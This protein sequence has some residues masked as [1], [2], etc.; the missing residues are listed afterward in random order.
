L[1]R[2]H[3]RRRNEEL[4]EV[5]SKYPNEM[6]FE[7]SIYNLDGSSRIITNN[8]NDDNDNNVKLQ[9]FESV[10]FSV[11]IYARGC[12]TSFRFLNKAKFLKFIII[13]NGITMPI[14]VPFDNNTSINNNNVDSCASSLVSV[15]E[16]SD[17]N[18][19]DSTTTTTLSAV[20]NV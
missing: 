9:L 10:I 20:K 13:I 14:V 16:E 2:H 8:N 18:I 19:V 3:R 6:R 15:E 1:L 11:Y 17:N 7:K 12:P 4:V 5:T